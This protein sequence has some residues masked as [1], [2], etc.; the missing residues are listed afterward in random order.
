MNEIR[1]LKPVSSTME[2]SHT[3]HCITNAV[4]STTGD[5]KALDLDMAI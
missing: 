2:G 4:S 3:H 5:I 1:Q